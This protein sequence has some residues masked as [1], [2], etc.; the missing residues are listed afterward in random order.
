MKWGSTQRQAMAHL[1]T[2][3]A[4][5]YKNFSRT[6]EQAAKGNAV[7]RKKIDEAVNTLT[8]I[9]DRP[10][11]KI[12]HAMYTADRSIYQ[13]VVSHKDDEPVVVVCDRFWSRMEDLM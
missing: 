1:A 6:A 2:T 8:R 3:Q 10:K 5:Y 4:R 12:V 11:S 7:A 9:F 13:Y